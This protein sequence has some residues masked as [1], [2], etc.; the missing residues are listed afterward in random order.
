MQ[1]LQQRT[2]LG[3]IEGAENNVDLGALLTRLSA[4]STGDLKTNLTAALAAYQ[5]SVVAYQRD[6]ILPD[7][8]YKPDRSLRL[9]QFVHS[10]RPCLAGLTT[11]PR[12]SRLA[13][14]SCYFSPGLC[15]L[16]CYTVL[17]ATAKSAWGLKAV[18]MCVTLAP[19]AVY[20][21]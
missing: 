16:A 12:G 2:L 5:S 19:G 14:T 20:N 13:S 8:S 3:W 1:L 17:W 4:V 6:N 11:H 15:C 18:G 7:V 21:P 9:R 10:F